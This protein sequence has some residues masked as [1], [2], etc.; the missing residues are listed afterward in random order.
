[1]IVAKSVT[2][3]LVMPC[4]K[5]EKYVKKAIESIL[6]QDYEDWELICVVNGDWI[7][8]N[9]T[10]G[11]IRKYAEKD[12]RIQLVSIDKANA[13][14]ARNYGAERSKG[15][16]ISFFSSDFYMYPGALRKWKQAFDEHPE[17]DFVY[18]GYRLM[19]EGK[20]IEGYIFSEPFDPWRL[21][22][23]PYIDGGFPMKREVWEQGNWDVKIKSLNDWDFWLTAVDNGFKGY[24]MPD[25]TYAAEVPKAGGLSNDS[26]S[27]WV[28][29]VSYIKKKH[30]I[31]ES[32]ICV[33]SLGAAPHGMRIAK[34]LGADFKFP[35]PNPKQPSF[36]PH[37]YKAIYLLGFYPGTGDS[38]LRHTNVFKGFN[39]KKVIHWIGTDILQMLAIA[40]KVCYRDVKVLM[41]ALNGCENIAEF[42]Q[43]HGEL[44]SL[45]I[46]SKILALP[47][48]QNIPL[49]KLP[50]TFKVAVYA[51]RTATAQQIYNLDFMK[52]LIIACP[53]I[54]FV[55]FGGGL[56]DFKP[57]NVENVGWCPMAEVLKKTSCLMRITL[58]DGLPVTPIEFRLAGRDAIT[59]VSMPYIHFAGSGNINEGNYS[60][61]KEKIIGLLREVRKQQKK[62]GVM[63]KKK[64]REYYLKLTDPKVFKRKFNKIINAK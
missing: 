38:A 21:R 25:P 53:D 37:S 4:F 57:K 28:K 33:V 52:D 29:R 13:C 48:E 50:K 58:H 49:M 1:M 32:D 18:S 5:C 62:H 54:K 11:I 55:L 12:N 61:R 10:L 41:D 20:M 35:N 39:G 26:H 43:T 14:S 27:N 22:I 19:E 16:Y 64:A 59:T 46:E 8:K 31:K 15:K 42:E 63:D 3:S 17:A 56:T 23:E 2:F 7:G 60:D 9:K 30:K 40:N 47:I 44:F 24:L 34:I 51:A 36:K 45:G 6:D